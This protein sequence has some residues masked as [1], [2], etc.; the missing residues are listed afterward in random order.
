MDMFNNVDFTNSDFADSIRFNGTF[1][2]RQPKTEISQLI[3]KGFKVEKIVQE[4]L[5]QYLLE[6][7]P[8][9]VCMTRQLVDFH[10]LNA[11]KILISDFNPRN[12][13]YLYL[14]FSVMLAEDAKFTY[15]AGDRSAKIEVLFKDEVL[16][17]KSY[18]N[19]K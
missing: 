17:R 12:H 9:S 4:N 8:L 16:N 13:S 5:N 10:L 7:D 18:Y 14:D 2:K 15:M 6:T 1:G 11:D 19:K 3:S